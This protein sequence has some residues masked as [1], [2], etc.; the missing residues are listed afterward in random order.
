MSLCPDIKLLRG[1]CNLNFGQ[2]VTEA[3][4]L[5]GP[6]EEAETLDDDL[7]GASSYV[8]HYWDHGFSLFFDNHKNKT[9][10]SVEVDNPETTLFNHKIFTLNE[11]ELIALMK[12]NGFSLTDTE[13]HE[14]GEKRISFDDA[15]LD[16]YYQN[17]KLSSVN[18]GVSDLDNNLY[19]SPN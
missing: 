17:G 10:N 7:L 4:E 5:F 1:F 13:N 8:M 16:C 11:K 15:N 14:W 6:A 18:F 12:S 9:F 2:S 19:F 3:T